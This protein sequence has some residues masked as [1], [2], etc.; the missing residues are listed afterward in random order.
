MNFLDVDD[1]KPGGLELLYSQRFKGYAILAQQG[2]ASARD[3]DDS[4]PKVCKLNLL[5]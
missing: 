2:Q 5:F 4:D 1:T 3:V